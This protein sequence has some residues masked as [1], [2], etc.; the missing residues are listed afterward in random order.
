MLDIREIDD[1]HVIKPLWEALNRHHLNHSRHFK[2]AFLNLTF[3]DRIKYFEKV[4]EYRI[5]VI[6]QQNKP[7][8]YILASIDKH[9]GEIDSFYLYDDLRGMGL[10]EYLIKRMVTWFESKE[11]KDIIVNIAAGNEDVIM[12]YQRMGFDMKE[13]T[14][15][16]GDKR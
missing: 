2:E 8:G 4:D 12:F 1:I 3:E 9:V 10:G 14:M 15:K 7:Y 13:Y 11:V 6:C 16:L 5:E